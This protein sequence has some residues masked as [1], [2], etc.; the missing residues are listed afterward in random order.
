MRGFYT[1]Y[2][3]IGGAVYTAL[4]TNLLLAVANLP[5]L[6]LFVVT[7]LRVTWL[8]A[9]AL[10]PLLALSLSAAFAVFRGYAAEGPIGVVRAFLRGWRAHARRAGGAGI[11]AAC[12]AF[13]LA[14]DVTVVWGKPVGAAAIPVLVMV[15]VLL[16]ATTVHVLAG[17]VDGIEA[18]SGA[19]LWKACLYLAVRRWYLTALSLFA[20][21]LLVSFIYATPAWGVGLAASPILYLVWTNSRQ[22]LLP[23]ASAP[24]RTVVSA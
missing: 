4:V 24:E 20:L 12:G 2:T 21:V 15:A 22:A 19:A 1:A 8:P 16:T 3:S 18:R 7:D 9:L 17:I 13:V 5:L 10:S 14:V 6:V 11:V 23:I